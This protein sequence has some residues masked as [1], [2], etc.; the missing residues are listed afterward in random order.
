MGQS[1]VA[2]GGTAEKLAL[3]F[4]PRLLSLTFGRLLTNFLFQ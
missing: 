1:S 4:S 2:Y 3:L